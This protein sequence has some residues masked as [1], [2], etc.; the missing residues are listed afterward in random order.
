MVKNWALLVNLI[1]LI[2]IKKKMIQIL[3]QFV[4]TDISLF[5]FYLKLNLY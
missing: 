5:I 3:K 4:K 2:L 1:F